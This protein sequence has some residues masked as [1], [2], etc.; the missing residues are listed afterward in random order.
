MRIVRLIATPVILLGLVGLLAW[1]GIWG[2]RSL[3]APLPSASPTPCVVESATEVT[4]AQVS[5]RILNGG[6]TTGL[7]SQVQTKFEDLGYTI[8]RVGNTEDNDKVTRTTIR[9]SESQKA[10]LELVSSVFVDPAVEFDDRVDGTV[11]VVLGTDAPKYADSP[12]TKVATPAGTV[13]KVPS[14]SPTPTAQ[15]TSSPSA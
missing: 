4:P 6:Y 1:A 15:P 12:L 7:A 8:V 5:V 14:P 11:D 10:Q 2:W 3:S 9:I 13:C